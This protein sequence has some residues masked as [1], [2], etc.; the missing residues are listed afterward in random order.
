MSFLN[1]IMLFGL[2][3][4]SIPIIIHLLNRRRFRRVVWA[5]MRFVQLSVEQNQKR[6]RIEDLILLILRCLLLA[7]IALA[8]ARPAWRT[9][10]TDI[11]GQSQ[12][13]AVILLD[14]SYSMGMSDGAQTR[15][16]KARK[17]AEQALEGMPS[18]SSAAILFASDIVQGA[19][20]EP[21]FD[22]NLARKT[23][24]E[25][26][27]TDRATDLAPAVDR[28][29]DVLR[30]R[31][32]VRKE[33][34]VITDG[35]AVGW[36]QIGDIQRNLD[37]VK[38]EI[39]AH[40]IFI[41]EHEERNLGVSELR[42]ASGLTPVKQPLRF[43]VQVS[44][45]GKEEVRNVP[46]S[47]SLD[48]EPAS[49]EFTLDAI[50][51]G[52]SRT[53]S[54]FARLRTE[55]FHTVAARIPEDRL[56][57]DDRRTL[58]VRAIKEVKV[59]LVDGEPA[60]EPRDSETYFLRHALVPVS[61]G[62]APEYFL[63]PV[64]ISFSELGAARFDDFD[65]VVLANVP[66]FSEATA[67][68]IAQYV[69]R[70]GGLMIFPGGRMNATFYNDALS[71]RLNLLP[72]TF[73][74]PRGQADQD[75]K[76]FQLQAKDYEH[77][78]VSIWNDPASGTLGSARFYRAFELIPVP[79]EK[80]STKPDSKGP[81]AEEAGEPLVVLRF[82]DG[83]PAMMER[84]WGLGRVL[85]FASTADTAWNDLPV[86]PA[87]VPLM[88]RALGAP[89]QRQDEGL[90]IRVGQKFTRN[91]ATEYA[92][93][94]ALIFKPRQ[95]ETMRDV[96]RI[97]RVYGRPMIQFDQTDWSGV[98][99]V[100]VADPPLSLKFAAQPNAA[101]SSLDELS[102]EQL[103]MLSGVAHVVPWAPN[104]SLKEMAV[105]E[106]TGIEFWLPII[107]A[108]FILAVVESGLAQW[109]SQEK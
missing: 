42:L 14:N 60:N 106:R 74:S 101:E 10:A 72:A 46:V 91:V 103:R 51:P 18:G 96:R 9:A 49:D 98:Y 73:G 65:V 84:P 39:R 27:L 16:E 87:F 50:P 31:F 23:I 19:I 86:R 11:F 47:L 85:V 94:D 105:R 25:A 24:R 100:T 89:V 8:L 15:F 62:E 5:A 53:I 6:M 3:A 95:N 104:V 63:K 80:P 56:P 13:A 43:E 17:A 52:G 88:H 57:A 30:G 54:L 34:Y 77:S 108:G 35:Q 33:I 68:A 66:E 58:A 82:S 76:Y 7:L 64:T 61:P 21:T 81:P 55:G 48:K 1:P 79:Y 32:S 59:L 102:P 22:F 71:R 29:I 40:F 2:A 75:E 99:E 83:M 97:D 41:N 38:S 107:L 92:D 93:K 90:T 28:A 36:R 70:G 109:F 78:I 44:N 67:K 12:V 37:R 45:Y 26:P 69:Q 20:P 4:V